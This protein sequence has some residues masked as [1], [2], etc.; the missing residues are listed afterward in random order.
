MGVILKGWSNFEKI[1]LSVNVGFSVL[2]LIIGGDYSLIPLL[3]VVA[4]VCNT[5]SVILIAKKKISNYSWAIVGAITYGFVAFAYTNTGEWMLN[6]LYYLPMNFVGLVMWKKN[7][8]DGESVYSKSMTRSQAIKMYTLT[9][10]LVLI[11]AVVI[12]QPVVQTFLYGEVTQYGFG[13][14]VTDSTS[15]VLSLFAMWLMVNRFSEQ[16]ILWIIV[17]I[18]SIVLWLITFDAVMILM[19][20]TMLVN[21]VYGY[22]RWATDLFDKEED[23]VCTM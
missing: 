16:W 6:W 5:M 17:D 8:D 4:G 10:A 15:T 3:S 13:K 14:F 19:W 2:L 22:L 12:Y 18:V 23:Y 7:S 20:T 11:Y 21:A 1:L 9:V